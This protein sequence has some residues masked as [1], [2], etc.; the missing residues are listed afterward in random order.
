ARVPAHRLGD[1]HRIE[2]VHRF[3]VAA[4]F[5]DAGR[6]VLGHAAIAGAMVGAD[7]IVVDRL[8][9]ADHA[10]FVTFTLSEAIDLVG[11]IH[12]VVAADVEEIADIVGGKDV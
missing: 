12:G 3:G 1:R 2:G 10:H 6:E 7:Q 11:G 9:H 8:G 5:H 4:G